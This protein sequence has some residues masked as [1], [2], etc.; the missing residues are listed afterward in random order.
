MSR[1]FNGSYFSVGDIIL[2]GKYKNKRGK[3]VGFGVNERGEPTVEI[4]PIPKGRKQNKVFGLF[5]IWHADETKRVMARVAAR[6]AERL[7]VPTVKQSPGMCG[8]ASVKAVLEFYGDDFSEEELADL[9]GATANDGVEA[10]AMVQALNLLGYD[11]YYRDNVT[12]DEV[13]TLVEDTRTPVI[14]DWFSFTMGHYSVVVGVDDDFIYLQDPELAGL[15]AVT[16][17]NFVNMWF[18]FSEYP[19]NAETFYGRRIVV[20]TP[21][22]TV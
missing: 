8:P 20:V 6:T 9:M 21:R 18:D 2:F 5:N 3:I 1:G 10:P 17:E 7:G 19:P 11:A 22:P 15:R 13:R 12:L 14:V 16:L 4:E